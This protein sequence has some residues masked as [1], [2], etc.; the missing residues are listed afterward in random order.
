MRKIILIAALSFSFFTIGHSQPHTVWK[1]RE[2]VFIDT[3]FDKL[4]VQGVDTRKNLLYGYF[5]YDKDKLKLE[6]LKKELVAQLYNIVKLERINGNIE[7]TLHVEKVESH[8]RQSLLER[9][10][11]L[12]LLATKYQVASYDGF[13]V[14]NAN[15]AMP[16]VTNESFS[17]FIATKKGNELFVI[18]IKL[19]DLEINDKAEIVLK[20]CLQQNIKPD[21][22]AYKLG[23]LLT[24]SNRVE[25][26]VSYLLQATKH[27]PG[28]SSAFFNLGAVCYDNSQYQNSIKYYQ[29]AEPLRPG[30]DRIPY[31]I[32][33]AQYAL[34]QYDKSLENCKKALALNKNNE[35]A[36]ALLQMLSSRSR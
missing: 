23:N 10:E 36:K 35:N 13:D 15:P 30:D 17:K 7:F 18:G 25:E 2:Q 3:I 19:Y 21:T 14:G 24:R 11:G 4:E 26:G 29:K 22:A 8:T 32:A 5:F 1:T 27:N 28:Y 20:Q 12:R 6:Q 31:G 9:E 34:Q 33:A 16:I